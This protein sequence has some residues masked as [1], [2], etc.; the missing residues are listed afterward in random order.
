MKYDFFVAGRWRNWKNVKE[1]LDLVR[2][3]GFTAYCFLENEY[4][5]EKVELGMHEN[6]EARMKSLESLEMTDSL[7]SKIFETD[8]T[9]EKESEIFLGVFPFGIS[10][11]MEAGVAY[12]LG[13]KCYAVGAPEKTETLYN[14]FDHIFPDTE[15]LKKWLAD[16]KK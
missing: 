6:I 16:Q 15:A 8:M 10:V 1:V 9:A 3:A 11:H 5:G 12:G 13:K 14:V 2:H 4:K 7:I